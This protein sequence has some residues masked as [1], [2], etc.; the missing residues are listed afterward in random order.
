M[1]P[2]SSMYKSTVKPQLARLFQTFLREPVAF[3]S[4]SVIGEQNKITTP[5]ALITKEARQVIG[6]NENRG[7]EEL[8]DYSHFS[9]VPVFM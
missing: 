5:L 4:L 9:L 2:L 7:L 8:Q 3:Q 6:T 1:P